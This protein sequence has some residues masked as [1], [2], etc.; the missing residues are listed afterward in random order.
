MENEENSSYRW[1]IVAACF[2]AMSAQ[3]FLFSFGVFYKPLMDQF[4]WTVADVALAPSILSVVY[5]VVVLPV[6]WAYQKLSI[7]P[8]ILMGGILMGS[9]LALS[10]TITRLWQLYLFYGIVAGVGSSTIWVPFTSAIMKWFI[11]KRGIA[12]A[13][14]LS[15]QGLGAFVIAPSLSYVIETG[16]W[17]TA[18]LFA[19]L[20]T[21]LIVSSASLVIKG[22]PEE[23]GL[24]P[25][26]SNHASNHKS[27]DRDGI[28]AEGSSLHEAVLRKQFWLLYGLWSFSQIVTTIYTQHIVLFA[29]GLG[30]PLILASLALGVIGL[31]GV[32]SRLV[33]G[34][35]LDR[36]GTRRALIVCYVLILLAAFLLLATRDA[37]WLFLFAAVFGTASGVRN[38]LEVPITADFFGLTHLGWIVGAFETAFGVGGLIGPYLAGYEYDATGGYYQVFLF[39]VFLSVF[40]LS[41][42]A[43]MKPSRIAPVLN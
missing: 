39:C 15:G 11:H 23:A 27:Q 26:S 42:A 35:F 19:S 43:T 22:S 37:L 31:S 8:I 40:S 14:A 1:V 3:A 18:F 2:F 10:S 9:G 36:I 20:S 4:G 38:L 6:S 33:V 24:K 7:K 29:I 16:G 34:L 28:L 13:I 21:F 32:I 25:Y 41:I 17:R 30:I 5:V 12:M